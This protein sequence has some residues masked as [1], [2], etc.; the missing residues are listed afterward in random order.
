[1]SSGPGEI[2]VLH[3]DDEQ[4]LGEVVAM[5]LERIHEEITVTHV[6][7]AREG[8]DRLGEAAFDCVVSDHDMPNMDGLE[9]LRCVRADYPDLPFI[10]FTGKGNEEIASDAISAGVTEYLQKDVGT[11]QYT[12]LANRIE[13]AVSERRAKTALEESERMLSTLISNLP[14]MVYRARN[15]PDWPMEFV[16]DGVSDLVGYEAEAIESG[17][18]SWSSLIDDT[19][20]DRLWN[21]V[22]TCIDAGEP[23]EVSYRVTT[24]E[25]RTRWLWERGRVVEETDDGVEILEGFITDITA[26]KE[27][28]QELEREQEFTEDL[29]DAIDDAFYLIG[30]DGRLLRWN[31]TLA[32]V[33]GY[34]DEELA[35]MDGA[36]LLPEAY[37]EKL[38]A[39]LDPHT[40]IG[41]GA[42]QAPLLTTDGREIPYEFRGSVIKDRDGGV[43]GIAGIG[44]DITERRERER[45]LEQ[46]ET[47]VENVG[48]PMFILDEDGRIQMANRAMA[49]HLSEDRDDVV[50]MPARTYIEDDDYQKGLE[51]TRELLKAGGTEW[52]TY[53]MQVTTADGETR[54]ME[55]NIAVLTDDETF[56]GTVGV[57]RDITERK[58]R[59]H[60]LKQYKTLVENVGDAMYV[61]DESG[62]V[63]MVNEALADHLGYDRSAIV[64]E[65]PTEFMPEADVQRG[66]EIIQTLCNDDDR[67][68]ETFEMETIDASGQRTINEDKI[69]PLLEDGSFVGTVG[70][71]RDIADR[72]QREQELKRYETIVQAVGDPVYTLD[73]EGVFT[74]VNDAIEPLTGYDP[75]GLVGNHIS[76]I[77]TEDDIQ[78]GQERIRELLAEPEQ[79]HVTLE[80]DI[81]T[82]WG[83]HVPCENNIVLLPSEDGTFI[84]TAGVIRNV[85]DRVQRERQLSEF[86]SV[87]S[88]DL[89]NPLNVVQGRLSLAAETGDI[90]HL[91]DAIDSADRME[92]LIDE[93]LT[94]AR[95][96]EMVG[97]TNP[98]DVGLIAEQAWENVDAPVASLSV[99]DS[100]AIEADAARL[101]ELLENLFRNAVE[102]GADHVT[103]TVGPLEGADGFYVADD[104]SGIPES[105]RERVFERGHTTSPDGTGFGLAIVED[106]A[107]AHGWTIE[108]TESQAGGA[109]FEFRTTPDDR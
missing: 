17:E 48:D 36:E 22:Q 56:I 29:I 101:R 21:R 91:N 33:T 60:K 9:F 79:D 12:V 106:I 61:L 71:I 82:R 59:Q 25:G 105:E 92:Q 27:R 96:G 100:P 24:A 8:L 37:H 5:H 1:M 66:A 23:F 34:S 98:V 2:R 81:V 26:R 73:D 52:R 13:R 64:G 46:Y 75:G 20:I 7:S 47:L 62:T 40:D 70:V 54:V 53:E 89:R 35:G 51:L 93:L 55:N 38:E 39:A 31:D 11:D 77:M 65:D 42:F 90:S 67:I 72:K 97:E 32:T 83:E 109:R 44:R 19:E 28:E 68:W 3:V 74:F 45:K 103:V 85:A 69:A 95:E 88:H 30:T 84:G 10:L 43:I 15:E 107:Q 57:V 4:D 18:V 108:L 94:L 6:R 99:V 14:G 16:S 50:G 78:R 104:G 63:Q 87:V 41:D 76:T 86:A 49:E 80:M 102:H 58:E